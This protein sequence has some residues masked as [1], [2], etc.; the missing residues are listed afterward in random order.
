[1]PLIEVHMAEGRTLEQKQQLLS[2]IT[3]A[4]HASIGVP[5]ASIRVWIHEFRASEYMAGGEI[6]ADRRQPRSSDESARG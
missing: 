3:E 4:V 2:A 5:V 6:L 1:M